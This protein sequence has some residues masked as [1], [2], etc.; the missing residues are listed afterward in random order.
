[1]VDN[2]FKSF[3]PEIAKKIDIEAT[4]FEMEVRDQ[5]ISSTIQPVYD[6]FKNCYY[7]N[8]YFDYNGRTKDL[9]VFAKRPIIIENAEVVS[10]SYPTFWEDLA[11]FNF[12]VVNE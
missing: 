12:S 9:Q 11:I 8:L 6:F 10:K 3:I 4:G 1:M 2:Y 5:I 7:L